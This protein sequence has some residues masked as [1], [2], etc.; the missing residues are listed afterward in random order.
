MLN[1]ILPVML[2]GVLFW[3]AGM[4]SDIYREGR[5]DILTAL[6]AFFVIVNSYSFVYEKRNKFLLI[7]FS[8]FL[9]LTGFQAVAFVVGVYIFFWLYCR[10]YRKYICNSFIYFCL[11][12]AAGFLLLVAFMWV[13]GHLFAFLTANIAYSAT[14][15]N[16]SVALLPYIGP[17]I[18]L[19]VDEWLAKADDLVK[20]DGFLYRILHN[21]IINAEYLV[22]LATAIVILM[23]ENRVRNKKSIVN[24]LCWLSLFIPLFMGISGRFADYYTWMSFLPA[25]MGFVLLFDS[26]LKRVSRLIAFVPVLWILC[27]GLIPKTW[28]NDNSYRNLQQFVE[29]LP[30]Q[31]QDIIVSPFSVFYD[32]RIKSDSCY[33]LG[34]YPE[35]Y[36]A[37]TAKYIITTSEDDY[38]REELDNYLEKMRNDSSI[39]VLLIR[40]CVNPCLKA[41]EIKK[42]F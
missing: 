39:T 3:I 40:E 17:L 8:M 9:I 24:I 42:L 27:T 29:E 1:K 19:D 14:L 25:L 7:F 33:F 30:V 18:G 36:M 31:K 21:Y 4:F 6:I 13:N 35:K 12:S 22:L 10:E 28:K 26:S 5:P 16:L 11:G 37:S 15:K 20:G 41:Y 2:F 34:I 32:I 23:V 38:G